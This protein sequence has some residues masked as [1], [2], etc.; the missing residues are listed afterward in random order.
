MKGKAN[1]MKR[2]KK[3]ELRELRAEVP[4]LRARALELEQE[5]AGRMVEIHAL[6]VKVTELDVENDRLVVTLREAYSALLWLNDRGY[7]EIPVPFMDAL[8]GCRAA[9]E[10]KGGI[11]DSGQLTVDNGE[12]EAESQ[13]AIPGEGTDRNVQD[14]EGDEGG[15]PSLHSERAG[16]PGSFGDWERGRV[17]PGEE[18]ARG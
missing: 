6:R 8:A 15:T 10:G 7:A 17:L 5:K 1:Q 4:G 2:N 3:V 9:L 14:P 13:T 11:V 18:E 12:G 16:R